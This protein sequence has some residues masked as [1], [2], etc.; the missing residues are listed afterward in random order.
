M[1][2]SVAAETLQTYRLRM[3]L[4]EDFCMDRR[5]SDS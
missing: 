2:K 4:Q 3:T 5:L 1:K